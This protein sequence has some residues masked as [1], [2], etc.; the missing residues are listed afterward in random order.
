MSS[1]Y[2]KA[3]YSSI[4][5]TNAYPT[6]ILAVRSAIQGGLKALRNKQDEMEYKVGNTL[7][8][9][10]A[11]AA[12]KKRLGLQYDKSLLP[13]FN[14]DTIRLPRQL[15]MEIP[16][17]TTF[18]KNRIANTEKLM[19]KYDKYY[20]DP[21]IQL[22]LDSDKKTL[23]AL[24]K[25]YKTG[26][27]VGISEFSHNSRKWVKNG[28]VVSNPIT[29]LNVL[30]NYNIRYDKDT[31]RMYYSDSYDFNQFDWGVPGIPFRFRGYIPLKKK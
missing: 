10:V 22:A 17:D 27:P 20:F 5:P 16:T 12:W 2:N 28:E 21:T 19:K 4:N 29:P 8:E 31:N 30:Q 15:E 25:T 13:T 11:D 24:R 3:L 23:E 18:I 26:K 7:G 14:G 1:K 9:K 6:W